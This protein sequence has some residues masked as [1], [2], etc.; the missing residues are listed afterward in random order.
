MATRTWVGTAEGSEGEWDVADNWDEGVV[1]ETGDDVYFVS[2]SQDLNADLAQSALTLDSLNFGPKWTGSIPD[3]LEINA[4]VL[5]VSSKSGA[6]YLEGTFT[7]ANIQSTSSDDPAI[8]F[9]SSTITTLNITGGSGTVKV[10]G[11]GSEISTAINMIG[12]SGAT[13]YVDAGSD[14]SGADVT[15]DAGWIEAYEEFGS[16]NQYG[17]TTEI[18]NVS[19]TLATLNLYD[20]TCRYAPT[21][22][23]VLTTLTIYGGLF[24]MTDCVSPSHTITTATVYSGGTI[25][26]RNGLRN[27]VYTNPVTLNGGIIKCD[28]GREVTVT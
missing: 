24:D 2:G 23:A 6:I 11:A 28:L 21:G 10:T 18:K 19:D 15:I 27:G 12:A 20:G 16:I 3:E 13:L 1:P 26:E 25:D 14:V 17:G 7:T 4:T 22:A 9:T 5:D 8:Q